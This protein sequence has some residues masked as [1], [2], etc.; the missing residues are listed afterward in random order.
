MCIWMSRG[1]VPWLYYLKI[2]GKGGSY[3]DCSNEA[4]GNSKNPKALRVFLGLAEYA[5]NL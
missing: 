2:W 1:V 4:M 5:K 3:E